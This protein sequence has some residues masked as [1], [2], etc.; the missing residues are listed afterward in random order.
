MDEPP[1]VPVRLTYLDLG[2]TYLQLVRAARPGS[3]AR[4][5]GWQEHGDGLHHICFGVDDVECELRRLGPPGEPVPPLGSG[6]G[7]P[8][9]FTGRAAACTGCGSSAR[10]W[11]RMRMDVENGMPV[12]EV[13]TPALVVDL[14][15]MERNIAAWQAMADRN[16]TK[17]RPH[18]KTHKA[19]A[20]ARQQ[21]AAGACG[22][23]SAK[24][25][26]AE[27]FVGGRVRRRRHRLPD[28]RAPTSG[29]GSRGWPARRGSPSTST[30]TTRRAA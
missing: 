5:R 28:G 17:L 27:V 10:H 29:R 4:A 15:R 19:P 1:E 6:R 25:T 2:N 18:I 3:S 12:A 21:I 30:A 23:A 9:G 20:I 13:P 11:R 8:A 22:I 24:P 16:G 14:D 7:R 26:E